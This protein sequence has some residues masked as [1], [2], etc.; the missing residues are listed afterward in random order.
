MKATDAAGEIPRV[1]NRRATGTEPHSHTGS[2]NPASATAGTC[3]G[4]GSR[5]TRAKARSGTQTAIAAEISAPSR[6]KGER[7]DRDR[8]EDHPEGR[9]GRRRRGAVEAQREHQADDDPE[10]HC[11]ASRARPSGVGAPRLRTS[12]AVRPRSPTRNPLCCPEARRALRKS[13]TAE[14]ESPIASFAIAQRWPTTAQSQPRVVRTE[15]SRRA[16]PVIR[17]LAPASYKG[18]RRSGRLWAGVAPPASRP[19]PWSGFP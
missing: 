9:D 14:Q 2:A 5:P 12:A 13:G 4:A 8:D 7:L 11:R 16:G 10:R 1:R 17:S 3:T 15:P 19:E 6:M 18:F